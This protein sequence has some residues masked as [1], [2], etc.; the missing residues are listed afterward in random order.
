MCVDMQAF[1]RKTPA[2]GKRK[3]LLLSVYQNR[4]TLRSFT[5]FDKVSVQ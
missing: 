1:Y 3:V 4:D 5:V 2:A